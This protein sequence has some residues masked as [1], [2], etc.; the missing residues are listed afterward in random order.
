MDSI[1]KVYLNA[2]VYSFSFKDVIASIPAASAQSDRLPIDTSTIAAR[3]TRVVHFH[4]N[5][6]H[7]GRIN[8]VSSNGVLKHTGVYFARYVTE[9]RMVDGSH[10]RAPRAQ[11]RDVNVLQVQQRRY[12]RCLI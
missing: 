5:H 10:L 11:T 6:V 1:S 7:I 2:L 9:P 12:Q 3:D 4:P 8:L